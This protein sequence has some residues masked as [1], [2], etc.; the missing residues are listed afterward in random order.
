LRRG[1]IY[2]VEFG[3][4]RNSFE[5]GKTRPVVIFQTDKLNMAV[6]EDIYDYFLVIPIS[7]QNDILTEEFRLK[8]KSRDKLIQDSFIVCNSICFLEKKYFKEKL[9]ALTDDEIKEVE[10]IIKNVLD[11]S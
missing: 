11:M 4:S 9:S 3:K 5:F 7:T 2:L 8:I 6:E 10:H 1:D